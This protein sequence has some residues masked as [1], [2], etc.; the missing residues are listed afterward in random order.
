MQ[1]ED[2][3]TIHCNKQNTVPLFRYFQQ[4]ASLLTSDP[5]LVCVNAYNFNAFS[6]TAQDSTRLYRVH[7]LP[8]YGWMVRREVAME[9]VSKWPPFNMVSQE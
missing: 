4:T 1:E 8:A 3:E 2:L 5:G 6:H 7:S 9:M